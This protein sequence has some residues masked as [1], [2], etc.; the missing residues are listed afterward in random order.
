LPLRDDTHVKKMKQQG[1][2]LRLQKWV[3][4]EKLTWAT[5]LAS[6]LALEV[7]AAGIAAF[8]LSRAKKIRKLR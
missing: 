7:M 1:C 8:I 4:R 6:I 5:I 3:E 2:G